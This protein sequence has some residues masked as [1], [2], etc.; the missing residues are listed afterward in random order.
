MQKMKGLCFSLLLLAGILGGC[1]ETPAVNK[2][3]SKKEEASFSTIQVNANDWP[4]T[5][6]DA[7]GKEIVIEKKPEKIASLWYFCGNISGI[8]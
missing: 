2:E 7:L 1:H 8:G 4:R 3:L 6:K 5:I